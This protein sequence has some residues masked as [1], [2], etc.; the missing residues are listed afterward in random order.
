MFLT[1]LAFDEN[2]WDRNRNITRESKARKRLVLT[3]R[4]IYKFPSLEKGG[5]KKKKEM[6]GSFDIY[7]A[8]PHQ[9]PLPGL[10]M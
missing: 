9:R 1:L 5:I 10:Q 2:F 8:E 3:L 6:R 4:L 7:Q